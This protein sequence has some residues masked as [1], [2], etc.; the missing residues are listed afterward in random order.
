MYCEL[1]KILPEPIVFCCGKIDQCQEDLFTEE[2]PYVQNMVLKRKKE[3]IA[4]RSLV[5]RAFSKLDYPN[6]AIPVGT[7]REPIWPTD[8]SGSI[9]HD[10]DYCCVA[11]VKKN[12]LSLVGIDLASQSPLDDN[13]K[14]LI[15]TKRDFINIQSMNRFVLQIDPYKLVFSIK[16][17]VYKCLFPIVKEYFDF[18][19]VTIEI[20]PDTKTSLINLEN[21]HL[22]KIVDLKLTSKFCFVDD[23]IFTAVWSY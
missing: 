16:E 19:D 23:Y 4:G 2:M 1:K 7:K 22:K 6:C 8:I 13:L 12:K 20:K 10:G 17:S 18:R 9:T 14:E 15:C 21:S 3:F 5:R 11:V